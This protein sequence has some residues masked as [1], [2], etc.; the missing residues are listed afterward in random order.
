MKF[1]LPSHL[2]G[3]FLL[4]A[5]VDNAVIRHA[6]TYSCLWF[7]LFQ[8]YTE[9]SIGVSH[10]NSMFKIPR[11]LHVGAGQGVG[12][13]CVCGFPV[14]HHFKFQALHLLVLYPQFPQS[15]T[16]NTLESTAVTF[17]PLTLPQRVQ[18]HSQFAE[19]RL[20][21]CDGDHDASTSGNS[22]PQDSSPPFCPSAVPKLRK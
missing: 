1:C 22:P 21:L 8:V 16:D 5:V 11:D 15:W 20:A 7:Q 6:S 2:D 17:K 14:L 4:P 19:Q 10:G 12:C 9:K 13:V 18:C 3:H